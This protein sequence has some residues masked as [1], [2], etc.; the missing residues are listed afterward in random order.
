MEGPRQRLKEADIVTASQ[1]MPKSA[2]KPPEVGRN[3][4]YRFQ[5]EHGLLTS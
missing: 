3:L 1:G 4:L 2:S 5:R